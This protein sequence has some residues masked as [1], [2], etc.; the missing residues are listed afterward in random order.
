MSNSRGF[1]AFLQYLSIHLSSHHLFL[2]QPELQGR[3]CSQ[4][5]PVCVF[6]YSW[7]CVSLSKSRSQILLLLLLSD[8]CKG[9]L[10]VGAPAPAF[11]FWCD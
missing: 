10:M 11:G 4:F 7:A 6:P 2:E 8:I 9:H 5:L 3:C 1:K